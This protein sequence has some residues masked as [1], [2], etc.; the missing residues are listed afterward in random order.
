MPIEVPVGIVD[1]HSNIRHATRVPAGQLAAYSRMYVAVL[2]NSGFAH[3]P[4]PEHK[5]PAQQS[6]V[7]AHAV[8]SGLQLVMVLHVS[9]AASHRVVGLAP[10]PPQQSSL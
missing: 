9:L 10:V 6:A 5:R 1:C 3:F 4:L 2:K 8:P 7:V